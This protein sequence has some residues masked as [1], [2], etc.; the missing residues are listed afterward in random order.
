MMI[1]GGN[2][3]SAAIFLQFKLW[4]HSQPIVNPFRP[5][6]PAW[7]RRTRL[8]HGCH[9]RFGHIEHYREFRPR[10]ELVDV[11]QLRERT[12]TEPGLRSFLRLSLQ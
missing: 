5:S 8:A 3:G 12:N 10:E 1:S 11:S 6:S 2:P 9:P 4:M 7:E